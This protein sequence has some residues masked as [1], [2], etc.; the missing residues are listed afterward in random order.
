M[1]PTLVRA[2]VRPARVAV[3]VNRHGKQSDLV[4]ALR[5][6]SRLWGGMYAPIFPTNPLPPDALTEF[7]LSEARPDFVYGIGLDR[8]AWMPHIQDCCQPRCFRLLDEGVLSQLYS[9][10]LEEHITDRDYLNYRFRQPDDGGRKRTTSLNFWDEDSR[11]FLYAAALFG[12]PY[13]VVRNPFAPVVYER[14]P[15]DLENSGDPEALISAHTRIIQNYEQSWVELASE[16]LGVRFHS[17]GTGSPTIVLVQDIVEDLSLFWNLRMEGHTWIP[18]WI[19]PLPASMTRDEIHGGLLKEWILGFTKYHQRPNYIFIT[20]QAASTELQAEFAGWLKGILE[21]T[22]IKFVDVWPPANRVP[23]VTAFESESLLEIRRQGRRVTWLRPQ[24]RVAEM[25]GPRVSWMVD[26][27]EDSRKRRS[28][29]ELSLPPCRTTMEILNA[30]SPP[31]VHHS[32]IAPYGLGVDSINVRCTNREE[33]VSDWLPNDK[34]ILEELLHESGLHFNAD[35]K[36]ACYLPA[37]KLLGGLEQASS[38]LTGVR[39]KILLELV[40]GPATAHELI[41]RLRLGNGKIPELNRDRHFEIFLGHLT[42][43]QKRVGRQRLRHHWRRTLPRDSKLQSLLE[44]WVSNGILR[45]L[46]RIGSCPVCQT[47]HHEV[48]LKIT[49]PYQCPGCGS[50]I[51]IPESMVVEYQLQ[52]ILEAALSQGLMPVALT[53]RFLQNLTHRGF[54]WLPGLKYSHGGVGGDID[55]VASCDGQLVLVECKTREKSDPSSIEWP[56]IVDQVRSLVAVGRASKA[57]FVVL[58]SLID[59]YPKSIRD[60]IESAGDTNLP[61]YLFTKDDLESGHRWVKQEPFTIDRP[62]SLADLI[63]PG[64]PEVTRPPFKETREIVTPTM[65]HFIGPLNPPLGSQ[66]RSEDPI[67]REGD[68]NE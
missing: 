29:F 26:L 17:G 60:E 38:T 58:A 66:G 21:G 61:V 56:N 68:Q 57:S 33:L 36:R 45:R 34:E 22:F 54:L 16:G 42:P 62:M 9:D 53:G 23:N 14:Y 37:L 3:L 47:T 48:G 49:R 28:P 32:A 27:V 40:K 12:I 31:T 2:R 35:E 65:T 67:H 8:E 50:K 7:R 1:S 25:F 6:L 64:F 55:I 52:P 4:L 63:P 30:P 5:F 20:S 15:G 18:R 46:F 10:N 39:G 44:H 24:S 59:D 11:L 51:P 41:G 43:T 13:E 19:I